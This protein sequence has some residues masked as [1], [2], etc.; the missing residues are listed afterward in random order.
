MSTEVPGYPDRI[1]LVGLR[2]RGFHGVFDHERRDGQEF[3]VDLVLHVD[4]RPA[5]QSDDLGRTVDYGELAEA[6]HAVVA[7]EPVDLLE[8]LASRIAEVALARGV[9]AVEVAVHKPGAP[10]PVAFADVVVR[11]H[12]CRDGSS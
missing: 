8:T 12:R 7:G 5:A 9:G 11:V 6:V 3:V 2:A 10:V 1:E 4:A